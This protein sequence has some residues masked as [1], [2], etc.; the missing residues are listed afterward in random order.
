MSQWLEAAALVEHALTVVSSGFNAL[1]FATYRS[2]I[3]RRRWAAAAL[4]LVNGALLVQALYLG[5]L[6]LWLRDSL[7]V[8][9]S[10]RPMLL[11]GVLPLVASLFISVLIVRQWL[12]RRR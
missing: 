11:T 9:L 12:S 2:S 10:P 6:P 1:Y 7:P 3:R 4:A 8:L 5:I